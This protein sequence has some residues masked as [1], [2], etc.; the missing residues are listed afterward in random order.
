M[1]KKL[2]LVAAI[3][4]G[5]LTKTKAQVGAALNFDGLND[6]V[7]ATGYSA[8][9]EYTVETWVKL[10]NINDQNIIAG[11]NSSGP[12]T[13][14]SHNL[15]L[16][17]GQFV[18][19]L[20][21]GAGK[22]LASTAT[23]T[24]GVWY[25]VAIS[26][27]NNNVMK[28]TVNGVETISTFS[29]GTSWTGLTQFRFGG[30]AIALGPFNGELDEVRI[31]NR[32]LC[33]AE[34]TNSMNG[35]IATTATDLIGNYHF[36]QGVAGANNSGIT[37]LT[38]VSGFN[39]NGTLTNMAL[40]NTTSNWVSPGA[41]VSGTTVPPFT[42]P[43]V[44]VTGNTLVCSGATTTLTASG[45]TNY[46][47]TS[48]PTTLTTTSTYIATS[49]TITTTFSVA[50]FVY[51]CRS[52]IATIT[53]SIAP[54]PTVNIVDA[55]ACSGISYTFNPTGANTY[56]YSS[57]SS[58]ITP[59]ANTTVTITGSSSVGC[60]S[61]KTISVFT[62]V[63]GQSGSSLSMDGINDVVNTPVNFNSTTYQNWTYECWAKSPSAP[64]SNNGYDGPMYGANMGIIW[65]HGSPSFAGA[66][67]V[68]S[69]S[70]TYW[71]ATY[72][73]L[74]GNTWYHL[75]ATYD[76]T[77][78]RA[79][80]NGVLTASVTT[81]GGL[82]NVAGSLMIGRHPTQLHFWEGAIDEARVW[83]VARTCAEINQNMNTELTGN[84]AGLKAYYKFNEG[85]PMGTNT[86]ITS[87]LDA[88]ANANTASVISFALTG[89]SSNYFLG[90]PFNNSTN[91][92]CLT[93]SVGEINMNVPFSIYPNPTT[94]ILNIGVKE[95]TQI[96]ILNI[97][98]EVVKTE[99]INGASK[100][101][102]SD[103]TT[104]VYFIQDSKS[105]K[106]IKFIKE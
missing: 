13:S 33:L 93:T 15:R 97:L 50:G 48:G 70:G 16:V 1:I 7:V 3:L 29:I 9:N 5:V 61:T 8:F 67:S 76:G 102:V 91:P 62:Q 20:Y 2:L 88:T 44:S 58:V 75:A 24:T 12:L 86:G 59:T 73:T 34:I 101:D 72:G 36:N 17:G 41:V 38:D 40:N 80:K 85:I 23:V 79:Y 54:N 77:V 46:D 96:F 89:N 84:E 6:Y 92:V 71:E 55:Y 39:H 103:L 47:W 98:G 78:L 81:T 90:A 82:A 11:T 83:T 35:E 18:H 37:A 53:V 43:V 21:D 25:H 65:N 100:L 87:A 60:I 28:I 10:N 105:G 57:G 104:G 74:L 66:A 95:Q 94:S 32:Q 63:C 27:K 52:N 30:N 106:A 19:A 4:G 45:A 51:N 64:V 31:W 68:Q 49:N 14:L 26:A 56:S 42:S 69:S 22:N 99:T